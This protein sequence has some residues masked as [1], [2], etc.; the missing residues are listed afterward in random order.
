MSDDTDDLY[1]PEASYELTRDTQ[2]MQQLEL[3]R[4]S[5]RGVCE[6]TNTSTNTSTNAAACPTS[7]LFSP[8]SPNYSPSSPV[9]DLWTEPD[10]CGASPLLPSSSS[11]YKYN[12]ALP[13]CKPASPIYSPSS[14]IYS[15]SS[16]IY[17]PSS[18]AYSPVK[19]TL[20]VP[21]M[22]QTLTS[23]LRSLSQMMNPVVLQ[24]QR[25][26]SP[27]NP[28]FRYNPR[29]VPKR[30]SRWGAS[31]LMQP[32]MCSGQALAHYSNP[33]P[34]GAPT[35]G[36]PT[37]QLP[38]SEA[39]HAAAATAGKHIHPS[40]TAN[41]FTSS[42][43][44]FSSPPP[45]PLSPTSHRLT[46]NQGSGIASSHVH[47]SRAVN[48]IQ[49]PAFDRVTAA[50]PTSFLHAQTQATQIKTQAHDNAGTHAIQM[51]HVHQHSQ[52]AADTDT[53]PLKRA[54]VED[55]MESTKPAAEIVSS[56]AND[57]TERLRY[58][59]RKCGHA[60]S[61]MSHNKIAPQSCNRCRET[62][63]SDQR[64]MKIEAIELSNSLLRREVN[65]QQQR[66][67]ITYPV[68]V[69]STVKRTGRPAAFN[70]FNSAARSTTPPKIREYRQRQEA[71]QQRIYQKYEN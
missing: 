28:L 66:S 61:S 67:A 53:E 8:S 60:W 14:P 9:H 33:A 56:S 3:L 68:P 39:V 1:D 62:V 29:H 49:P 25:P 21:D 19:E 7:P 24:P 4:A 50:A 54:R 46:T 10:A 20:G 22:S 23:A 65:L 35:I 63:F 70:P 59:C 45:P 43:S 17:S 18:P 41:I 48:F 37:T 6:K 64:Q 12:P 13:A 44:S 40:R 36:G 52:L 69:P 16:P 47:P 71:R 55:N 42:S 32:P 57:S 38:P 34:I 2:A 31:P 30:K 27:T 5:L 58:Y 26:D 15:P 11:N 51:L